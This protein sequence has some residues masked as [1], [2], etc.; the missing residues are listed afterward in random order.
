MESAQYWINQANNA[1]AWA[2]YYARIGN[3][4]DAWRERESAKRHRM[5]ASL[6]SEQASR[7]GAQ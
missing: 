6:V 1:E 5:R 2:D 3:Y 7:Q 4:S